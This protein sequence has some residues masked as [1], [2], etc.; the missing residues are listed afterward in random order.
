MWRGV[1][2]WCRFCVGGVAAGW[3]AVAHTSFSLAVCTAVPLFLYRSLGGGV[4]L[5]R[6][7]LAVVVCS[8]CALGVLGGVPRHPSF[9][10][11]CSVWLA[12]SLFSLAVVGGGVAVCTSFPFLSS[13]VHRGVQ[14]GCW[15]AGWCC[16]PLFC[17]S[18]AVCCR[19]LGAAAAGACL[20]SFFVSFFVSL[21]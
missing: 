9:R 8:R 18:L 14:L 16:V 7:S 21:C 6:L 20:F 19:W 10:W 5:F 1:V 17:F 2:A 4:P 13:G 12:A 3:V 15:L 11:V